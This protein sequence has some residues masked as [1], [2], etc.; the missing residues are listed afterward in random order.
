MK[1]ILISLVKN[2]KNSGMENALKRIKEMMVDGE[3]DKENSDA[4]EALKY[5]LY[6]VDVNVLYDTALRM[7]DFDLVI[8]VAENSQKDPKEYFPFLEELH[9]LEENYRKFKIDG[10][11]KRY[12]SALKHLAKLPDKVDECL[13]F[14]QKH[15]LY[16][17]AMKLFN[18][19]SKEYKILSVA[20]GK[21][22]MS[23]NKYRE[24]GI[25]LVKGGNLEEALNAFKLALNWKDAILIALKLNLR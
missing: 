13:A 11:L 9:N 7:Y 6:M 19:D 21:Y 2:Q 12:T 24:A 4:K 10:H 16:S 3:Q 8:L 15:G 5:L 1:P 22:L 20:Y 23:K 17:L 18:C 14:T 25:M